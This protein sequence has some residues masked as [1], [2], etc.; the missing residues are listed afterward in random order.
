MHL[1]LREI[2]IKK[3]Y[4]KM[5]FHQN[6]AKCQLSQKVILPPSSNIFHIFFLIFAIPFMPLK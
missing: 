5:T 2:D 6:K 3:T 4:G 1:N